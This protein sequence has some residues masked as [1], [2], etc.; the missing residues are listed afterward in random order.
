MLRKVV[1]SSDRVP[2][3]DELK[4]FG[5]TIGR[6][7]SREGA[8][9]MLAR[10]GFTGEL[11]YELFFDRSSA[12]EIWDALMEAGNSLG[13]TPMGMEALETIRIEAGLMSAGTEFAP[14]VDAFEAGLGFCV[15]LEKPL[16]R[17]RSALVRNREA[18]RNRLVGLLLRGQDVPRSGDPVLAGE[19]P[20]GVVTSA[21]RSPLLER[22]IAMAR[23]AVEHAT[24]GGSLDVGQLDQRMKRLEATVSTVP[25]VDA[26]RRLVRR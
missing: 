14:G 16:F 4:W 21:T 10:T 23:V 15:D 5:M 20:V 19:R 6:L 24:S 7:R 25:F 11:G 12:L 2:G 22:P 1:F 3:L 8:P 13:I 9:F 18:Q 17:G 26:E